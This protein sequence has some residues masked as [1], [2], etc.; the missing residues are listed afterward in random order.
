MTTE[1]MSIFQTFVLQY[2]YKT[3]FWNI[4]INSVVIKK[5]I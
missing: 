5:Q 2:I 1:L 4:D 3:K